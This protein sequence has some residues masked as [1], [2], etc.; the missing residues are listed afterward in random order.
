MTEGKF[1][2]PAARVAPTI[3]IAHGGPSGRYEHMREQAFIYA[4]ILDRLGMND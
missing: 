4:F 2:A 3:P 1:A